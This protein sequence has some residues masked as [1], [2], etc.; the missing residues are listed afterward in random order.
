MPITIK[1][2]RRVVPLVTDMSL[3]AEHD[4]AKERFAALAANKPL[5]NMEIPDASITEA[6]EAVREIEQQM[7]ASRMAFTI[8]ALPKKE[9]TEF[10]ISHPPRDGNAEDANAG[11]N[12]AEADGL[13]ALCIKSVQDN[14]GNPVD[15][16][17]ATE[18]E[19]LAAE[20]SDGQWLDF[21]QAVLEVNRGSQAPFLRAASLV[22]Q[23]SEQ[24]S[25]RP[26]A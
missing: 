15:F 22:I 18:W 10:E 24:T 21:A 20:L 11:L 6:A 25:K 5:V 16:D 8:E 17:P 1:R 2:A 7:A 4:Q 19:P 26:N 9:F 14:D 23:R 13:I 3:V 12:L